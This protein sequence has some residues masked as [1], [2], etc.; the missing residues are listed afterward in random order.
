[1]PDYVLPRHQV[2]VLVIFMVLGF[3]MLY[4]AGR[5]EGEKSAFVRPSNVPI[6]TAVELATACTIL[7]A[8][9]GPINDV[10]KEMKV[11]LDEAYVGDTFVAVADVVNCKDSG[12]THLSISRKN[13]SDLQLGEKTVRL[14]EEFDKVEIPITFER[15]GEYFFSVLYVPKVGKSVNVLSR[16]LTVYES[17]PKPSESGSTGTLGGPGGGT[18]GIGSSGVGGG[19]GKIGGSGGSLPN[20][21][22]SPKPS[23][24][25]Q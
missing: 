2:W 12:S 19:T 14:D 18:G 6:N 15:P 24:T 5:H 22:A 11:N 7:P 9:R 8:W 4:F 25:K 23:P 13:Q 21:P 16:T 10:S 17:I 1:M 20:L 3:P